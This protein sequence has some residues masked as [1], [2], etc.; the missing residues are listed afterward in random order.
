MTWASTYRGFMKILASSS[1]E[2]RLELF[3]YEDERTSNIRNV[4]N[5]LLNETASHSRR[6]E[7]STVKPVYAN[8]RKPKSAQC[9]KKQGMKKRTDKNSAQMEV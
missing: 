5:Y 8:L 3:Q 9:V 6:F 4:G 1:S 2:V 7:S